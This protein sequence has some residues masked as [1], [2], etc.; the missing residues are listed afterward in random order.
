MSPVSGG[1]PA[2]ISSGGTYSNMS[3]TGHWRISHR[4]SKV[5]VLIGLECFILWSVAAGNPNLK[6]SAYSVRFLRYN[7][8]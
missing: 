1:C 7:V 8:S 4:V 5:V 3:D 6:I 2:Y